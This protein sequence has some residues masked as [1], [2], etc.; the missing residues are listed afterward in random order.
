MIWIYRLLFLPFLLVLLPAYLVRMYRRGGYRAQF[1]NRLGRMNPLPE[2]RGRPRVWVHA[3]SVGE[4]NAVVPVI[5]ALTTRGNEVYFTTTTTTAFAMA[6]EKLAGSLVGLGYFPLDFWPF[7]RST[8][9]RVQPDLIVLTEGEFWPELLRRAGKK[10]ISVVCVNARLSD[11][12]FRR[13]CRFPRIAQWWTHGITKLLTR[14]ELDTERFAKLGTPRDRIV[15]TGNIKL[16]V[17][18]PRL[19]RDALSKL[20]SEMGLSRELVVLGS[21]TWDGEE[22]VLLEALKSA[23]EAGIECSLLIVPRHAERRGEIA[24]LLRKTDLAWHQRS[25][26]AA[27]GPVDVCL[28]DTTGE[29]RDLTQVADVAFIGKSL[30]PYPDGQTPVEAAILGKPMLFGPGMSDFPG[31]VSGLLKHG[32]AEV[33]ADG[34]ALKNELVKLLVDGE[35]RQVMSTAAEKW[36]SANRGALEATMR[37]IDACLTR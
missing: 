20:K 30:P 17:D 21:S 23:L 10:R 14:S 5:D 27:P 37:E 12:S 18:I 28:A 29:L 8:W 6:R 15:T 1:G 22:A 9:R 3:V 25:K 35:R 2:K 32:A 24:A 33:V 13:M 26:G 34:E 4:T 36:H 19:S 16:E 31:V 7:V 11:R